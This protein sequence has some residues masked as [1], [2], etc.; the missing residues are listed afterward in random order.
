M[1]KII[2]TVFALIL[3]A[4]TLSLSLSTANSVSE[5]FIW[6][7]T[8]NGIETFEG[9][10]QELDKG[11]IENNEFLAQSDGEIEFFG[12]SDGDLRVKLI[13]TND[14]EIVLATADSRGQD[15]DPCSWNDNRCIVDRNGQ[16]L[17]ASVGEGNFNLENKDYGVCPVLNCGVGDNKCK[18][19]DIRDAKEAQGLEKA[20]KFTCQN[21]PY[22]TPIFAGEKIQTQYKSGG[23]IGIKLFG[24]IQEPRSASDSGPGTITIEDGNKLISTFSADPQPENGGVVSDVVFELTD[25]NPSVITTLQGNQVFACLDSNQDSICDYLQVNDALFVSILSPEAKTYNVQEIPL[26][27]DS[28]GTSI[29]YNI[30]DIFNITYDP[31]VVVT[32]NLDDGTY[33]L[34]AFASDTFGNTVSDSV[35]FSVNTTGNQTDTNPP[36]SITNLHLIDR[37]NQ[38]LKWG[39]NNPTDADFAEAIVLLD[40][41]N[42]INTTGEMYE[43]LGLNA[44]TQY[45]ITVH[46]LDSNGNVNNTDVSRTDTTL[47]NSP[48]N[49]TN[50]TFS[51]SI[52]SPENITYTVSELL[53]NISSFNASSIWFNINNGANETFTSEIIRNFTNGTYTLTAFADN[54][55]G[56]VTS[57][58]VTFVV[59]TSA[60]NGSGSGS[61]PS[62]HLP[63]DNEVTN[64]YSSGGGSGSSRRSSSSSSGSGDLFVPLNQEGSSNTG[65]LNIDSSDTDRYVLTG[66]TYE[67]SRITLWKFGVWIVIFLIIVL[68]LVVIAYMAR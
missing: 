57:D 23:H 62:G 8:G 54:S 39:W 45:T 27:I 46:T 29:W 26:N 49:D 51:V 2:F 63:I 42:V 68:V 53:I 44:D 55:L 36:G 21:K 65:E 64:T 43:A 50:G 58:Q 15:N 31:L 28:N 30:N 5:D 18:T 6:T 38:S 41:V 25:D 61:T 17:F 13:D 47:P 56:N 48:I 35:P 33:T 37:T 9:L 32:L 67:G 66:E 40:G 60:T 14:V 34:N 22:R 20:N 7:V 3:L 52:E 11:K 19:Q 12:I 24:E 4:T 1:R 10:I 59:N 16:I